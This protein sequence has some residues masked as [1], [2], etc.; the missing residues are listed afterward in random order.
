[1]S[2][3]LSYTTDFG[4]KQE[5]I[6]AMIMALADRD[7]KL[8]SMFM[9]LGDPVDALKYEWV[10]K[11][12]VGF[13]DKLSA[14]L[15]STT[16]T[17]I[18]VSSGTNAPKRYIDGYTVIRVDDELMLCV[19][20]ITIVTNSMQINVTRAQVGTTAATHANGS[21]VLIIGNPR[22]EGFSAGRDDSQKGSRQFNY[23]QIFERELK[24]TGSSQ[25][26]K[27][28]AAEPQL[29]RQAADLLPELLKELQ[30]SLIHGLRFA[31]DSTN[32]TDR[33]LGG[34]YYWALNGGQNVSA[35]NSNI[36]AGLIDDVIES[37][38]NNGG[39]ANNLSMLVPTRQQRK[40]NDLKEARIIN[41]GMSQSETNLN[42]FVES[43]D[44]G[45]RAKVQVILCTDL[46][47]NE[48]YFF[49][50]SKIEV[51]PLGNEFTTRSFARKPL[52]EDG[53]FKRE[54][55]LGE[56]TAVFRNVRETLFRYNSLAV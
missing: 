37:Y 35:N 18:T 9:K 3:S 39:D 41:G 42:N 13:K 15:S 2:Q 48:V 38:L 28:V 33:K 16:T 5:S 36:S 14:A 46:A 50:K 30:M 20:T 11:T 47:D 24:L 4:S 27:A 26:I 44:F 12:L 49:D 34:F 29:D 23:T 31:N 43:Y 8:L 1:M 45:S 22:A 40:L 56:Y 54:M 6:N 25:A 32:Y 52:P 55:I 17:V 51:R 10:D 53:D 7:T 21:Q 19:S